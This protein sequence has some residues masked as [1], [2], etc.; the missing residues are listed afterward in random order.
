MTWCK[1]WLKVFNCSRWI[2]LYCLF[3]Y[4]TLLALQY[5]D[6]VWRTWVAWE[7]AEENGIS[8]RELDHKID[9]G[10]FLDE[11]PQWELG[12]PHWSIILHE[13]FL[14]ATKRGQKEAEQMFCQGCW[15]SMYNPNSK[16]DQSAMELV[17]YHT[18][19][20]EIRDIYQ[21]IYLLRRAPGLP[22]CRDK[23]RRKAIQDILPSLKGQLHRHGHSAT[24]RD[25]ELQEEEQ[26]RP[27]QW[28]SYEEALRAG[29]QRALDTAEALKSDIE[30]LSQRRRDRSWTHSRTCSQT[31]SWSRSHSRTRSWSRSHSRACSQNH[32]QGSTWNYAPGPVMDP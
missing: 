13:M 1:E 12:T 10:L 16:A 8:I 24:A 9:V 15:G 11:Y 14:H 25:L 21:S 31:H 27:N 3:S 2:F 32:S 20:K 6:R 26:F 28:G 29:C 30:R 18:S 23:L 17:G 7:Q 22:S 5:G 19:W 4:L